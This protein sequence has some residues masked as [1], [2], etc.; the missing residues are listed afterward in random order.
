MAVIICF[1]VGVTANSSASYHISAI[2]KSETE[3]KRK[4]NL[5]GKQKRFLRGLGHQLEPLV[6]IGKEGLT[7]N[8]AQATREAFK[9]HELIKVKLGQNCTQS[10]E[11]A[12][13]ALSELTGAAVAQLIGKVLLLYLPNKKLKREHRIILPKE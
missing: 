9:T 13:T 8:V 3:E 6:Y 1:A 7:D 10:V 12:A 5:L 2:M 4:V 11:D